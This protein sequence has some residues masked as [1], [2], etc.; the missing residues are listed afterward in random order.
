MNTLKELVKNR[1]MIFRLAKNDFKSKFA[2]S[3]FGIIWAFVQPIVIVSIYWIIFEKGFKS[4]PLDE[5]PDFPYLLWLIAGMCPWFYFQDALLNSSNCLVEYSY[6]VKKMKFNIDIIPLLKIISA[7]FVHCFFVV[8]VMVVYMLYGKLPSVYALQMIYY[9]IATFCFATALTYFTCAINVFFRDMAQIVGIL[10]QYAIWALP[11]MIAEKQ[12]PEFFRPVL[13]IN[14]M[15]Y[16]I[17]GY[18]DA[19]IRQQ[20]FWE[21]P[22]RTA[23]F[24]IVVI[25]IFAFSRFVF[26]KLKPHF[27]DVM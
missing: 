2:G 26:K 25:A 15:Y 1:T 22:L 24:W 27:A 17:E 6:I 19:L 4:R 7:T 12:Y 5:M 21:H 13:R 14:P 9:S 20:G 16:I 18:R 8:L 3:Y 10:L 11:I 23:Y